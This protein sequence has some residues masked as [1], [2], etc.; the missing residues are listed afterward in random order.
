VREIHT[1]MPV[2][3]KNITM[4]GYLVKP[5]KKVWSLTRQTDESVADKSEG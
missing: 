3:Q 4:L 1:R 5:E 2:I